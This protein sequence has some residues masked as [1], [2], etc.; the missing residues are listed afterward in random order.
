MRTG[1]KKL[2]DVFKVKNLR[3]DVTPDI[4]AGA[5]KLTD[6][7]DFITS[8]QIPPHQ[9]SN[10]VLH[11]RDDIRQ[12]VDSTD[13]FILDCDGVI[14]EGEDMLPYSVETIK[15]LRQMNKKLF[16]LT[17]GS[18]N[19]REKVAEKL[20]KRG[21]GVTVPEVYCA[22][23][24]S[25]LFFKTFLSHI[26]KVYVIGTDMLRE[27]FERVGI[28]ALGGQED[29]E[30]YMTTESF[31]NIQADN[32]VLA[33]VVGE[34]DRFN[35]YKLNMASHYLQNKECILFG[36][37][38]DN[39]DNINKKNYGSTGALTSAVEAVSGK[40]VKY[41]AGKPSPFMFYSILQKDQSVTRERTCMIGDR[42]DTDIAF[43]KNCG[44]ISTLVMSGVSKMDY[45]KSDSYQKLNLRPN[46]VMQNIGKIYES[47]ILNKN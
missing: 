16:F 4:D 38:I 30:K 32:D 20:N 13:T 22:T 46:Y 36:C 15:Y 5:I 8:N 24:L 44:L 47:L 41:T 7:N 28:T 27:E 31:R 39:Y 45:I 14:Y 37:N 9:F 6:L 40:K 17:N 3:Y 33:V 42:L 19:S 29:N 1:I 21:V 26:S 43:A 12:F 34:D 25:A 35:S 2:M 11:S 18:C 23:Y 10:F